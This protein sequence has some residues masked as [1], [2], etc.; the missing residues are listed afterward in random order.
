MPSPTLHNLEMTLLSPA[1][2]ALRL[3]KKEA[4]VQAVEVAAE[5]L[6]VVEVVVLVVEA[7]ED[8]VVAARAVARAMVTLD[9]D[10]PPMSVSCVETITLYNPALAGM[11]LTLTNV[12]SSTSPTVTGSVRAASTRVTTITSVQLNK[13]ICVHVSPDTAS[14]SAAPLK[15]AAGGKIGMQPILA[16]AAS[17]VTTSWSMGPRLATLS[18]QYNK[19]RF[20][21]LQVRTLSKLSRCLTTAPKTH[22]LKKKLLRNYS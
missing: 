10:N 14:T 6:D 22:S 11:I 18:S 17:A 12:S 21:V 8:E 3:S 5:E 16:T 2:L 19:F 20:M 4:A 1:S 15:I 13:L 7:T 9:E